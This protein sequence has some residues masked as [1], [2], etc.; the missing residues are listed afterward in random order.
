MKYAT[1][2]KKDIGNMEFKVEFKC[3]VSKM[4]ESHHELMMAD[5]SWF[6]A[7]N[8][9]EVFLSELKKF[10]KKY[11]MFNNAKSISEMKKIVESTGLHFVNFEGEPGRL[12]IW[13]DNKFV[14]RIF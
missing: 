13:K 4:K 3:A 5:I 9:D 2:K 1:I 11:K 10:P 12:E 14:K 7:K 6:M 8:V